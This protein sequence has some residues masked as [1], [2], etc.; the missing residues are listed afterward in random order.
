MLDI[1]K[2]KYCRDRILPTSMKQLMFAFL[3]E[4][5]KAKIMD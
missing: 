5:L 3:F 1:A 2:V 4:N